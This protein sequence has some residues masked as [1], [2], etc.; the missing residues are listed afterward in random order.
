MCVDNPLVY[1]PPI[2][3]PFCES[4][5][6]IQVI[7]IGD[8]T[9]KNDSSCTGVIDAV[10][11]GV[12]FIFEGEA[13]VSCVGD[14][15]NNV[16][17]IDVFRSLYVVGSMCET[18]GLQAL[19][20]TKV[21]NIIQVTFLIFILA[22]FRKLSQLF[23]SKYAQRFAVVP[24]PARV[25]RFGLV[26]ESARLRSGG[27][28]AGCALMGS[29]YNKRHRRRYAPYHQAEGQGLPPRECAGSV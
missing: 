18:D 21:N 16:V 20:N 1:G 9:V 11:K 5:I 27:R 28:L 24:V 10:Y 26:L 8:P 22:L 25:R 12:I 13:F 7:S 3:Q 6:S 2:A 4:I 29:V 17:V 14:R 19:N 15:G 23:G